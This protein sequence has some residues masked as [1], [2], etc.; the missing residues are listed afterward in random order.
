MFL[1]SDNLG[2]DGCRRQLGVPQP[3][4]HKVE[5]DPCVHCGNTEAMSKPFW[6]RLRAPDP[7]AY[8]TALTC[9]HAVTGLQGHNRRVLPRSCRPCARRMLWTKS[10]MVT[11]SSG[12]GTAR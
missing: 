6:A 9:R 12:T 11:T 4:L 7:R 8:I 3:S 5:W 2:I 1:L 10:N